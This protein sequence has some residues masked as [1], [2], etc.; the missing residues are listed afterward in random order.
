MKHFFSNAEQEVQNDPGA[1]MSPMYYFDSKGR[2]WIPVKDSE[3]DWHAYL[4]DEDAGSDQYSAYNPNWKSFSGVK[5]WIERTVTFNNVINDGHRAPG[6]ESQ[7]FEEPE[8]DANG[9]AWL[10][11]RNAKGEWMAY[12]NDQ[13]LD[14]GDIVHSSTNLS[15]STE[16][17]VRDWIR[18]DAGDREGLI[19]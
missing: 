9:N 10:I 1:Q 16:Q 18:E 7:I 13:A 14:G 2:A 12:N 5:N 3:G 15:W 11:V 17:H 4:S 8:L 6:S 19:Y